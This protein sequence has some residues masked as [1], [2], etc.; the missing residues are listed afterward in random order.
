MCAVVLA[1]AGTLSAQTAT[2]GQISGLVSDP[3][4]A[5]VP[6]AKVVAVDEAGL[7]RDMVTDASGH[8]RLPQLAPGLYRVE[9][10][11]KG[12]TPAKIAGVVVE[13]TKT[14]VTDVTLKVGTQAEVVEVTGQA[15]MLQTESA[16]TGQV[17]EQDTIRQLPLPTRNFQQ[18]LTLSTGA[19][20]SLQNSSDLG[21]GDATVSVNGNRTTSNAVVV[22]G[23]DASSI[24][25]GATPNLAVPATDTLQEFI[26]QTSL[27]DATQGRNAGGVVA[28]VTKSGTNKWHGNL[29]EF[30]RNTVL[31]SND[32]FLKAS[33][34]KRPAYQR[35]QFGGTIG[36]PLMKD[37]AWLFL[38]YQGTRE[39][40]YTSLTNSLSS[41]FEVSPYLTN[42]RSLTGLNTLMLQETGLPLAYMAPQAYNILTAQL[43]NGSYL[44][45]SSQGNASG[46]INLP[47][48]STY[49]ED[50]VN[51]NLDFKLSNANHLSLK[52]FLANNPTVQ[53]LY[54]FAGIGNALQAPGA[55]TG[56]NMHQRVY[57]ATDTHLINTRTINEFRFGYSSIGGRFLP[58]EPFTGADFGIS[59]PL[60]GLFPGAPTIS[61]INK[62]DLGPS[63][64]ADNFSQVETYTFGDMLTLTRGKHTLKMG[65]DYKRQVINLFFNAYTRGQLYFSS[66]AAFLEGIP[67]I[68][69]QG[70][71]VNNRNI[72]AN[73]FSGFLQDDWKVNNRL[74]LNLGLRYDL[75]NPFYETHGRLVAFDPALASEN[76]FGALTSGFVQAGNGNLG[77]IP[78][79]Q[80]GLVPT[81]YNNLAPRVGFSFRPDAKSS[82]LVVRGGFGLYYDR[83][84]ARLYNSQ[85]FNAPY[86]MIAMNL[87]T[88]TTWPYFGN[89]FVQVPLPSQF[90]VSFGNAGYFPYGGPPWVL[91]ST[92]VNF[93]S[94]TITTTPTLVPVSGIYPNRHNFVTPYVEQYNLDVQWQVQKNTVVDVGY[95]GSTGRK[96]TQ[97]RA[98]NQ[99]VYN[100]NPYSGPYSV[101]MS[102][103]ASPVLGTF[104]EAT[105]GA[106]SY[107]SLQI[108]LTER[109][110]KG[111]NG[112]V[113][114][115]YSHSI[116]D[117]SGGDV[118]D[119]DGIPGNTLHN[120][121]ASSD[122]DRRHRLIASGTYDVPKFY[123]GT[124]AA[125][126]AANG[127]Q[128]GTIITLQSGV[129]F[130]IIGYDSAF[131]YTFSNLA[132]GYT[133]GSAKGNGRP[134]SRLGEYFN[135]AA[136]QL[137]VAY[138]TDFGN[139]RNV[140]VGPP[141]KNMDFSIVK[142][143]PIAEKQKLEFRT[144][145]FN[146]FNHPN[147][148]NP[149]NIQ[150]SSAFGAIVKTATGPRVVQFAF[151]Y[152]F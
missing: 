71:G 35:N 1:L 9:I 122:F 42:D 124:G 148:A 80:N 69:L 14:T 43:P 106:S 119:L 110:W 68:T 67:L 15:P 127:W 63:P 6:G 117:Y 12:F 139:L 147:F 48:R 52:A 137:P 108:S 60:Q 141:Q 111:F 39:L 47:A 138:S 97:L 3:A 46:A 94:Y 129:P 91:P 128:L 8:F 49:R 93:P 10:S 88:T 62:V 112:L 28:A 86:D 58:Q 77:G 98:L 57:A 100:N 13:I 142:F 140:L 83:M 131:A 81:D 20:G 54:N 38:S 143:F 96:L 76:A 40:N 105:S 33:D 85:V 84:N 22:N 4:G 21:R 82:S 55:P 72:R 2:T 126:Y 66:T 29:Y 17:I 51:A 32:Y 92:N 19:Q 145:F 118:N 144:E 130:N 103:L 89:P 78:K 5:V 113:S 101:A 27:Y 7:K 136:F 121:Y 114:Y 87:A 79:V 116:D 146:L 37:R 41:T 152:S 23:V 56:F 132:P 36:G 151:K 16:A 59:G 107:N 26:V 11:A 24:G 31:N 109:N 104:S 102:A 149:V 90:P 99:Q 25:T 30:L 74:T 123:H 150:S 115:T 64:L 65:A 75:Y 73:D 53:G 95:V 18:L 44:V 61:I 45:P 120:Y 134:E 125:K 133:I 50:Q 70:S 34:I 135:T